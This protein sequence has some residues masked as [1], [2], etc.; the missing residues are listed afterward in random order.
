LSLFAVFAV[1]AAA[2]ASASAEVCDHGGGEVVLC[3]GNEEIGSPTEHVP[4]AFESKIKPETTSKLEV[5]EGGPSITC[6]SAKNEGQFDE[7]NGNIKDSGKLEVSDLKIVFGGCKVTNSKETEEKCEI[8]K[9]E[10]TVNGEGDSLD[11]KFLS[12]GEVEF[13]PSF[14]SKG[15]AETDEGE[16][17]VEITIKN[18]KPPPEVTCPVKFTA[19]HV[20]GKQKCT[21]VAPETEAV[22]KTLECKPTGSSLKFAGKAAKFELTELVFLAEPF[23]GKKWSIISS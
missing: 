21:I 14:V 23:K 9:G 8:E 7:K 5:A 13:Y 11:G 10:I 17:F 3:I 4:V 22:E 1:S 2:S 6:T 16:I 19:A 18:K 12:V 15:N 20:T